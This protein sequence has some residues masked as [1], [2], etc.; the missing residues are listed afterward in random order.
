MYF[1]PQNFSNYKDKILSWIFITSTKI[2][3]YL[4]LINL[5][6]DTLI[7]NKLSG[8]RHLGGC[9]H[10]EI[11]QTEKSKFIKLRSATE[12][13]LKKPPPAGAPPPTK[14]PNVT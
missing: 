6:A 4:D 8:L 12:A 7:F 1:L 14:L 11:T 10:Q 13:L 5:L 3:C 9:L 2:N